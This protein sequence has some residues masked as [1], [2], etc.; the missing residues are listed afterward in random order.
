MLRSYS[1]ER[2]AVAKDLI[3]FDKEWARIMSERPKDGADGGG[4]TPKF[5]RYFI[6][7]GRYTAGMS[8]R[9]AQ[10]RLTAPA[11]WQSLATGFEIGRRLHSAPVVRLADGKP[12]ELGH[13]VQ[14][15]ARWR[16]FA[17]A[18][19]E[20]P[21]G[22]DSTIATFCRFLA[23]DSA[24]PV[25]RHTPSTGDI[26]DVIDVR[27]VFQQGFRELALERMPAM[28]LPRKGRFG[29]IDYEK[30]FCA[31]QADGRDIYDLRG[32]DRIRGCAV[33]V[34][35][36]QYVAHVVPLDDHAEVARFFAGVLLPAAS[37]RASR[38]AVPAPA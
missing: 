3:E 14:A 20:D 1:D 13:V 16:I 5:Q 28:L 11:N 36:D 21:T 9:Y 32:I 35:P 19:D 33:I 24:S 25:L 2:H 34:R 22:S 29:L 38:P 26:D 31:D 6:E 30:M 7:H 23:E 17:F 12:L 8:V 37:A 15:D 18:G 27:A 4:D 10:S